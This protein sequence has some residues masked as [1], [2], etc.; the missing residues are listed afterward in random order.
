MTTF[1]IV[2][3][4]LEFD[5]REKLTPRNVIFLNK[6]QCFMMKV[7]AY[8]FLQTPNYMCRMYAICLFVSDGAWSA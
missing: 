8:Q 2:N 6:L 1:M 5:G 7:R 4:V 3:I